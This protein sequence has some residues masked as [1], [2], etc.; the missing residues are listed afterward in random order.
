MGI[1]S[2]FLSKDHEMAKIALDTSNLLVLDDLTNPTVQAKQRWQ[3]IN[4]ALHGDEKKGDDP[5][6]R[7]LF[8]EKWA[9]RAAPGSL[10]AWDSPAAYLVHLYAFA[11]QIEGEY[12]KNTHPLALRR[13]DL[14]KLLV[15]DV[16]VGKEM[17]TLELVNDILSQSIREQEKVTNLDQTLSNTRYPFN[18][19]FHLPLNQVTLGLRAANTSLGTVIRQTSQQAPG[20]IG[21]AIGGMQACAALKAYAELS[22]EQQKILTE[23]DNNLESNYGPL[24]TKSKDGQNF[25]VEAAKFCEATGL[26]RSE[27]DQLL[28]GG[29]YVPT[30]SKKTRKQSV[31]THE[32]GAIYL[33]QGENKAAPTIDNGVLTGTQAAFARLNHLIRLQRW[34]ALPFDQLDWLISA[35]SNTAKAWSWAGA[36]NDGML[37][38]LGL[39]RYLQREYGLESDVFAALI[40]D[41]S[42]Y[43]CN[44]AISLLDRVFCSTGTGTS[45]TVDNEVFGI[46]T[47]HETVQHL[48]AGL[49]ISEAVFAQLAAFV[50]RRLT[51]SLSDISM[52]YRLVKIPRLLGLTVEEGLMLLRLMGG[53]KDTYIKVLLKTTI[54]KKPRDTKNDILDVILALEA[55]VH[56]LK[57]H[58]LSVSQVAVWCSTSTPLRV[59]E[60]ALLKRLTPLKQAIQPCLLNEA[61]FACIEPVLIDEEGNEPALADEPATT[62]EK[63][64]KPIEWLTILEGFIDKN[65]IPTDPLFLE[66]L[67]EWEN[68]ATLLDEKKEVLNDLKKYLNAIKEAEIKLI[69][70]ELIEIEEKIDSTRKERRSKEADFA[71]TTKKFEREINDRIEKGNSAD[72]IIHKYLEFRAEKKSL[73]LSLGG[74]L[75]DYSAKQRD[76][77]KNKLKIEESTEFYKI[78]P[79]LLIHT[80]AEFKLLREKIGLLKKEV[81]SLSEPQKTLLKNLGKEGVNSKAVLFKKLTHLACKQFIEII[82]QAQASQLDA[83]ARALS[84]IYDLPV[85]TLRAILKWS[86]FD[87][88]TFVSDMLNLKASHSGETLRNYPPSLY[89]L[90]RHVDVVKK[91]KLSAAALEALLTKPEWMDHVELTLQD[92]YRLSRYADFL[93]SNAKDEAQALDYLQHFNEDGQIHKDNTYTM[94]ADLLNWEESEVKAAVEEF[95]TQG[96]SPLDHVD[97]VMRVHTLSRQTGLSVESLLEAANLNETKSFSAWQ[98]VGQAVI[99]AAARGVST[100]AA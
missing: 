65:G 95:G 100:Q 12:G 83:T 6:Y 82:A 17:P 97:W 73:R 24:F 66:H 13:P 26:Q 43:A 47:D 21:E 49:G 20:F 90:D 71:S 77:Y 93:S 51:R 40:Y 87:W 41:I 78:N 79:D 37:R 27:L 81:E 48:C 60:E 96:D 94:L 63:K 18:L 62:A 52:F 61:S 23:A 64:K 30:I 10:E 80:N 44:N 29:A 70:K 5:T 19:P 2:L 92:I 38:G 31:S 36:F 69:K 85:E 45:I 88:R 86:Y 56:W 32:Y 9:E 58:K 74:K 11:L 55:A 8:A 25:E 76:L 39:F 1:L 33:N 98:A 16:A 35:L 14:A 28:A 75:T 46:D 54:T 67:R 7:G 22:P 4:A 91:L 84:Q 53:G 89:A 42:P 99:S 3:Q 34:L 59:N 15:D 72:E 50:D 68:R 57:A